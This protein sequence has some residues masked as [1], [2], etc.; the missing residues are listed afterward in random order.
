M[1]MVETNRPKPPLD[2]ATAASAD[3]NSSPTQQQQEHQ[4]R[5]ERQQQIIIEQ[6]RQQPSQLRPH[7]SRHTKTVHF[8]TDVLRDV[9]AADTATDCSAS[10]SSLPDQFDRHVQ[11]LFTFIGTALSGGHDRCCSDDDS[12]DCSDDNDDDSDCVSDG[13][14]G[15]CG[16]GND[17]DNDDD[18]DDDDRRSVSDSET[19]R[20]R[21]TY[22]HRPAAVVAPYAA[23]SSFS[24]GARTISFEC[25]VDRGNTPFRHRHCKTTAGTCNRVFLKKVTWWRGS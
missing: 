25:D 18:D 11:Q 1:K 19:V 14:C 6:H 21:S 7:Q 17:G 24:R 8:E 16:G 2:V 20:R 15:G 12:D 10:V 5:R 9:G 13:Y 23:S 22:R 3:P 4:Q